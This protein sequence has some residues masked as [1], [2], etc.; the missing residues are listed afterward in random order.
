MEMSISLSRAVLRGMLEM[1]AKWSVGS[2][3]ERQLTPERNGAE[4][5]GIYRKHMVNQL[6]IYLFS[7]QLLG[8][9]VFM[10]FF[11]I[12]GTPKQLSALP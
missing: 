3:E 11:Y 2:A 9:G 8:G 5:K 10:W 7:A 12:G 1:K 4:M 6:D